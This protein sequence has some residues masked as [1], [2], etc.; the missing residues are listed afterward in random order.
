MLRVRGDVSNL[1]GPAFGAVKDCFRKG[2][3]RPGFRLVHF[4]V[5]SNH[6]HAVAEGDEFTEPKLFANDGEVCLCLIRNE[7]DGQLIAA[8]GRVSEA[9]AVVGNYAALR[10]RA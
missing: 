7:I 9:E 8:G 5:Q 3:A 6:V 10:Y 2:R 4:S 1:R